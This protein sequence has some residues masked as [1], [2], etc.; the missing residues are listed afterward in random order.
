MTH[1]EMLKDLVAKADSIK[2]L[3]KSMQMSPQKIMNLIE[4]KLEWKKHDE[5]EVKS[6]FEMKKRVKEAV[7]R[8]NQ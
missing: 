7:V 8:F 5:K 1:V 4:G 3:G 2:D 6:M